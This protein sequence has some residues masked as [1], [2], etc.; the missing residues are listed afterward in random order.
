MKL[1]DPPPPPPRHQ[2]LISGFVSI[3]CILCPFFRLELEIGVLNFAETYIFTP[4]NA[5]MPCVYVSI[6]PKFAPAVYWEVT[7]FSRSLHFNVS[8]RR[9]RIERNSLPP[10][11]PAPPP[12]PQPKFTHSPHAQPSDPCKPFAASIDIDST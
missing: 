6:E 1:F 3:T 4:M 11:P 8:F 5:S 7:K 2:R 10:R 12:T 9:L